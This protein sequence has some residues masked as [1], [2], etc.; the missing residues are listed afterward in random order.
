MNLF[1]ILL[2]SIALG[3]DC[4]VVSFAHGLIFMQNRTKNSLAL[5]T[6]M[7]FFQGIM[8]IIGYFATNYIS[9]IVEPIAKWLVFIIFLTLGLKFIIEA[10]QNKKNEICC[11]GL[12]C[13]ITL[14]IATSID[15]LVAGATIK[16]TS[17]PIIITCLII[18]LVSFIMSLIGF[19]TG[20]LG[21]KVKSEYLEIFGGL[22]LVFLAVKSILL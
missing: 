11:F 15:A 21:K 1:D 16:L 8:P 17:T 7:G 14:G 12:K 19:W 13:I 6:A 9:N 5:A 18:G 22:I 10:F 20:N 3:I 4:M 2:L